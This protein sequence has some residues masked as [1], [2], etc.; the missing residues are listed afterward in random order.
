VAYWRNLATSI[1]D[2]ALRCDAETAIA[3]KRASIDG[4]ALFWTIPRARSQ[5]LLRLL[6]AYEILADYLDC[7]SERGAN[8]GIA[9]GL[10]LHQALVDALD[11]TTERRH[12]YYQHHSWSEDGDYLGTLVDVCR[13]MCGQLPSYQTVRPLVLDAAGLTSVLAINHE[14]DPNLRDIELQS[15]ATTQFP[16]AGDLPWWEKS[17]SASAW[18]TILALLALAADPAIV[19]AEA[20]QV[21]TAYLPW[22]SLAGTMLDSYSDMTDDTVAGEHSYVAHYRSFTEASQRIVEI[23]ERS[24][25]EIR[26]LRDGERHAVIVGCMVAMF[27]TKDSARTPQ[28]RAATDAIAR[29]GGKLTRRL[30]PA[31]RAWRILYHQRAT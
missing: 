9:N 27:L 25:R 10:Q 7:T 22:V 2:P 18:L 30:V 6:V 23:V 31:L 1:P 8:L 3:R 16:S 29:A 19:G 15:W 4:A 12:D 28:L 14:P 5:A 24:L 17:A 11:P 21:F 13:H 20:Q 26:T